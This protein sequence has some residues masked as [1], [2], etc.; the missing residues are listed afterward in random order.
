MDTAGL[1]KWQTMMQ[2]VS[3]VE[4]GIVRILKIIYKL[5]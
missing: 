5:M 3:V 2:E 1:S 4:R